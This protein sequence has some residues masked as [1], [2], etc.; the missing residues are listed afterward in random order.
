MKYA[1]IFRI[2]KPSLKRK[3]ADLK[4]KK[5][6]SA[7]ITAAVCFMLAG[8]SINEDLGDDGLLKAPMMTAQQKEIHE[9]LTSV[10]GSE[11]VLKYPKNGDNRS[12]F[13]IQNIDDEPT[14]EAIVFYQHT[15]VDKDGGTVYVNILDQDTSGQWRSVVDFKGLG[16][17]VDR[18]FI[19]P[20][21]KGKTPSIIIGY[22]AISSALNTFQVYSYDEECLDTVYNDNYTF[23][24]VMD[25]NNDGFYN[26]FKASID[27][28]SGVTQGFVIE[29]DKGEFKT[30]AKVN[31]SE[32][33]SSFSR[34][35][36]GKTADGKEA[37]FIDVLKTDGDLMTD[38]ITE[39][40]GTFQNV[41]T[42]FKEKISE[43]TKRPSGYNALDV[44]G[45][46]VCEIPNVKTVTGYDDSDS[47]RMLLTTWSSFNSNYTLKAKY[48]G[49]YS[50]NDG[51][52]FK[53]NSDMIK[54]VT[55]KTDEKT[56]ET[57]FYKYDEKTKKDD[58]ELFRINVVN[59]S[60]YENYRA[61]G[62][63]L[64]SEQGQLKYVVKRSGVDDPLCLK[65]DD[66]KKS[67]Y[68]VNQ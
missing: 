28:E 54:G 46:G 1:I 44:D 29:Q 10:T 37:L 25:L 56:G 40:Y 16:A 38:I 19:T 7:V 63:M 24:T 11:I 45:D 53:M 12:A 33:T 18:I 31:M 68:I 14:E 35:V 30:L 55:V 22:Q 21:E 6:L 49:Y 59:N 60:E 3:G 26:I 20:L 50:I 57:V 15:T 41:A 32:Y 2:C 13:V 67:F 51:Y 9:A 47:L 43:K 52:F 65:L 8:C 66:I 62:Y 36:E 27:S 4:V 34:C 42:V 58:N 64:I 39:S 5:F 17:E 61:L 48:T 23:L